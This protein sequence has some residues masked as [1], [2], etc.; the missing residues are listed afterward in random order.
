MEKTRIL[1]TAEDFNKLISG[2]IVKKDN[3]E[4]ALQDIGY[5]LMWEILMEKINKFNG[6]R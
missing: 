5:D 2:D 4:I 3:V 6:R 1:F